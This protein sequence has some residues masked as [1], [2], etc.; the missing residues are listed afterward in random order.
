MGLFNR[1]KSKREEVKEAEESPAEIMAKLRNRSDSSSHKFLE[2]MAGMPVHKFGD[3]NSYLETGHKRVWATHRA[4]SLISAPITSSVFSISSEK[5]ETPLDED[6]RLILRPNKYDSWTEMLEMWVFHMEL[7]GNAFWL[8]DEI[9]AVGR[10]TSLYPLLPQHVKVIPN[11]TTKIETYIYSVNGQEIAIP[12]DEIIHFKSTHP[13]DTIMGLGSIEPSQSLYSNF[14]NSNML[15]EKFVERG[16]TLSGI[17]TRKGNGSDDNVEPEEW[18]QMKAKFKEEYEGK[19]NI[20]KVA[21]LDGDWK[22][23]KLGMT[24]AEMQSLEKERWSISQIFLNHGVPLSVVGLEGASNYAT[25]SQDEVNFRR[26]KC[27]PLIKLLVDKINSDGFLRKVDP[28]AM[29]CYQMD[30]L[31]NVAGVV[32]SYLPLVSMGVIT[33]NEMRE[34]AGLPR[35]TNDTELDDYIIH[36]NLRPADLLGIGGGFENADSLFGN[37]SSGNSVTL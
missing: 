28:S 15:E 34:M 30:G 17:M 10:P 33:R 22:Y 19:R 20:G 21:F 26:Y 9:D 7:T 16:A 32:E 35:D 8:K 37:S 11:P 18:D 13:S 4:C 27:V 2:R 6:L 14:I 24:M 5:L 1:S 23:E 31:V 3:F 12:P 36:A 29:L 25:A